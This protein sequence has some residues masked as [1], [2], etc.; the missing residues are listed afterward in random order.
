MKEPRERDLSR[1]RSMLAGDGLQRPARARQSAG[2]DRKVRQKCDPRVLAG[3]D[4]IIGLAPSYVVLV[5]YC[6][7]RRDLPHV[8]K[9]G[10]VD[11]GEPDVANL[12]LAPQLLE[13]SDRF[14]A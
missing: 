4:D 6:C 12:P 3:V 8:A 11:V 2:V 9:F 10:G 7:N 14:L 13:R 1:C 5:L